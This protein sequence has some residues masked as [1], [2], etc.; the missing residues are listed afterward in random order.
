MLQAFCMP[1]TGSHK[2][3]E[4]INIFTMMIMVIQ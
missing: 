3:S 4:N 1:T 2:N